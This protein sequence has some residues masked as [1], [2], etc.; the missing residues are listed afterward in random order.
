MIICFF[1][2]RK[3]CKNYWQVYLARLY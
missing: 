2:H 3:L 1:L